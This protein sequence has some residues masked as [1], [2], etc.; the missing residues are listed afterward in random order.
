[1]KRIAALILAMVLLI[2]AAGC[3]GS[4]KTFEYTSAEGDWSIRIPTEFTKDKESK[5]EETQ[6]FITEFKNESGTYMTI[7]ELI[8][9]DTEIGPDTIKKEIG[10]DNYIHIEKED[11]IEHNKLGK[12]YGAHVHDDAT[13]MTMLYYRLRHKDKIVSVIVYKKAEFSEEEEKQV[14]EMIKSVKVK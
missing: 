10:D 7:N 4:A 6:A 8:D 5:D 9:K 14:R 1:M 3:S 12:I 13:Q 2:S 11:V